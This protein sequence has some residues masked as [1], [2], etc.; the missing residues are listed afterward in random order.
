MRPPPLSAGG[1]TSRMLALAHA[2]TFI[3]VRLARRSRLDISFCFPPV[4]GEPRALPVALSLVMLPSHNGS[5][6]PSRLTISQLTLPR[7]PHRPVHAGMGVLA[8]TLQVPL[9]SPSTLPFA[10]HLP[11]AMNSP[12]VLNDRPP[13]RMQ[14]RACW[15]TSAAPAPHLET[16]ATR[17]C[18]LQQFASTMHAG[19][20]VPA[21]P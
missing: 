1:P 12:S 21:E 8:S 11:S 10:S 14:A 15:P 17:S 16:T 19:M 5:Q 20:G 6:P 4:R 3:F 2:R 18:K 7:T 13:P 9:T